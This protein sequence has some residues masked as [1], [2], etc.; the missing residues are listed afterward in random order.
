MITYLA[1]SNPYRCGWFNCQLRGSQ[2]SGGDL[3]GVGE[4]A[5]LSMTTAG[6][7]VAMAKSGAAGYSSDWEAKQGEVA[8]R[9]RC[10]G[11]GC[12]GGLPGRARG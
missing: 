8:G 6:V 12:G 2:A 11:A 9:R 1:S 10:P 3:G 5:H 7:W 4:L